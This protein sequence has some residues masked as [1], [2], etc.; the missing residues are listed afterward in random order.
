MVI[1]AV[2]VFHRRCATSSKERL[3]VEFESVVSQHK[4]LDVFNGDLTWEEKE[5]AD[6]MTQVVTLLG[7]P[8]RLSEVG[9]SQ[10]EDLK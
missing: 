4:V 3:D 2:F 6:T 9:V 8:T 5:A 7:M 10:E 1:R